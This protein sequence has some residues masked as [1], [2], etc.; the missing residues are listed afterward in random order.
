MK[1]IFVG[2]SMPKELQ[3]KV[4]KWQQKFSVRG[5]SV[6]GGQIIDSISQIRWVEPK[7]LH[8]TLV[9]P[10]GFAQDLRP[11]IDKLKMVESPGFEIVF[12]KI[13]FGPS[14]KQPRMV[15]AVGPAQPALVKLKDSLQSALGFVDDMR[16]R[17]YRQHLTL[18]R[19]KSF[20]P[21]QTS[22]IA[23]VDWRMRVEKFVLYESKLLPEGADYEVLAEFPL[24]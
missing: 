11:L 17:A 4:L 3:E 8:V 5:G 23:K 7:N 14:A 21:Q 20:P 18:A 9:P 13:V 24:E 1:R 22:A 10:L 15:W 16:G 6:F 2:I 12:N 19:L